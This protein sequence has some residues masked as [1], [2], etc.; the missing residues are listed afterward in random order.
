M[1]QILFA[2]VKRVCRWNFGQTRSKVRTDSV[3]WTLSPTDL[4]P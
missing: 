3:R 1:S 4:D 2:V